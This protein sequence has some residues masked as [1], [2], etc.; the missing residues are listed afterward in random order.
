MEVEKNPASRWIG[1]GRLNRWQDAKAVLAVFGVAFA[2]LL[3]R[4]QSYGWAE[5]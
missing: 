3:Y 4:H 2:V 5:V 1:A